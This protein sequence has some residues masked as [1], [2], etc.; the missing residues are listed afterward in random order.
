MRKIL[1]AIAA[2]A[3]WALVTAP[4]EACFRPLQKI[5]EIR[6]VRIANAS[7]SSQAPAIA[8]PAAPACPGG[9]C[10]PAK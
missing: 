7:G 1:T 6:Q 5:R 9:V 3:V 10:P 2:L 4:A 8:T